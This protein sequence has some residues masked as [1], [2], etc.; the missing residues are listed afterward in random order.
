VVNAVNRI[1]IEKIHATVTWTVVFGIRSIR[2][3]FDAQTDFVS[4][5]MRVRGVCSGLIGQGYV[6]GTRTP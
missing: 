4:L 2:D 6:F 3:G 5:A 1:E